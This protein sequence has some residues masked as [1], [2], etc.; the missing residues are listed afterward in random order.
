MLDSPDKVTVGITTYNRDDMLI[1][2]IESILTQKYQNFQII[3]G[4]DYL[5]KEVNFK[6]LKIKFDKR[7]KFINHKK[8]LGEFKNMNSLLYASDSKWF[9]WLADDDVMHNNFLQRMIDNIKENRARNIIASYSNYEQGDTIPNNFNQNIKGNV[10]EIFN[11]EVFLNKYLSNDIKLIGC[12]GVFNTELLKLFKGHPH[13][14]N[15]FGPYSDSFL[16][17]NLSSKGDIIWENSKLVFLRTHK[18]SISVKSTNFEAYTSA[19]SSFIQKLY[20]I[21]DDNHTNKNFRNLMTY[22]LLLWFSHNNFNVLQRNY[23]IS[24]IKKSKIFLKRKINFD[25]KYISLKYL[26]IYYLKIIYLFIKLFLIN[27]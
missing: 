22:K 11:F 17:I 19:E 15:S 16:P 14:G 3:V 26:F 18:N 21:F 6:S 20:D 9:T 27:K 25:L 12:Y 2:A 5:D 8:S 1:N 23:N 10:F 13:L 24:K 4:N 7:I